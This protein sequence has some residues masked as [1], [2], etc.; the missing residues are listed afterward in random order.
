MKLFGAVKSD[1]TT[2]K[3]YWFT[4]IGKKITRTCFLDIKEC[5][6]DARCQHEEL[7]DSNCAIEKDPSTGL[8]P[9]GSHRNGWGGG[10][11][12]WIRGS[13]GM[14]MDTDSISAFSSSK[15]AID[16][17]RK[18]YAASLKDRTSVDVSQ[19]AKY[20]ILHIVGLTHWT[21][22]SCPIDFSVAHRYQKR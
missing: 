3:A 22:F 5:Q 12:Y 18:K 6:E 1:H 10:Y 20:L 13:D 21:V 11:S 17:G 7:Q 8:V 15:E 14:M 19:T 4:P 2:W 16:Y 9:F